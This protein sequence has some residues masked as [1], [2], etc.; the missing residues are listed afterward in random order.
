MFKSITS[1]IGVLLLL[2]SLALVTSA[3]SYA[4]DLSKTKSSTYLL[5]ADD[6]FDITVLNLVT[7]DVKAVARSYGIHTSKDGLTVAILIDN[8]VKFLPTEYAYP[9]NDPKPDNIKI[10]QLLNEQRRS[11][12]RPEQKE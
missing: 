12:L 5:S 11:W 7:L 4:G 1:R 8:S 9:Q 3:A 2:F 10:N 6:S